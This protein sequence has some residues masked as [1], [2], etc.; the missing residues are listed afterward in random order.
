[1]A[2]EL[3]D[4]LLRLERQVGSF[5]ELAY[6]CG[7]RSHDVFA[8]VARGDGSFSDLTAQK[9]TRAFGEREGFTLDQVRRWAG[10][11]IPLERP[12]R[13]AQL[14]L[15]PGELPELPADIRYAYHEAQENMPPDELEALLNVIRL[16]FRTYTRSWVER[17]LGPTKVSPEEADRPPF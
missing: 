6:Q 13:P 3:I 4:L 14:A 9:L 17:R 12:S 15:P 1:V 10:L 16:Q 5:R 7:I 8:R 11:P 2:P